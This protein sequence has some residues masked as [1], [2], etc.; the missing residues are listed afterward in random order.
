MYDVIY[1]ELV[2]ARVAVVLSEPIFTDMHANVVDESCQFGLAQL[3]FPLDIISC[4]QMKA[5][6]PPPQRKMAM[7]VDRSLWSKE[8]QFHSQW[9]Q[10]LTKNSL[11]FH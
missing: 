10:Q 9:H 8:E 2:D 4:L 1:D 3:Q 11:C 7:L 5:G 6:F